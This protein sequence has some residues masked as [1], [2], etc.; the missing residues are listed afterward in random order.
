MELLLIIAIFPVIILGAYIYK[1]DKHKEPK[2]LLIKLFTS[3]ILACLLVV[4]ITLIASLLFPFIN[5]NYTTM[6]FMEFF[7]YIFI[8]ISLT[9]EFCKWLM[10]YHIGYKSKEFD[11]MYDIIVYSVFVA[12]GFASFENLLYVFGVGSIEVGIFRGILA[13]PGHVCNGI[14]MGYY[15]SQAKYYKMKENKKEEKLEIIKSI[16]IPTIYHGIYDYCCLVESNIVII[17]FIVFIIF[18][19]TTSLKK[20]KLLSKEIKSTDKN[21]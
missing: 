5:K 9:E 17:V 4:I 21:E 16:L 18:L 1:K 2:L 15:L 6:N 8:F 12:L 20:V 11:E 3:G 13:I 10:T 14:A 19:Y 7:I